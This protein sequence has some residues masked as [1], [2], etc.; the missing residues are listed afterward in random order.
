MVNAK[1]YTEQGGDVTHIGGKLVFENG[2]RM[3]GSACIPNIPTVTGSQVKDVKEPFNDLIKY[4]KD[5]GLMA[6]DAW[7]V[8]ISSA[9]LH[10]LPTAET[11]ANSGHATVSIDGTKITIALDC[12]VKDLADANHGDKWGTHKWLGF[13]VTTGLSSVAGVVFDD[14]TSSVTLTAAD[15]SEASDVGLSAGDFILY[16]KA[17]KVF[18]KGGSFTLSGLGKAETEFTMKV[19]ETPAGEGE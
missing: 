12:E 7:S 19:T 3:S 11:L 1:N 2:A 16:I 17:E 5:M 13:G 8:S 9:T 4:L 6:G 10:G 14:G 15:D 18:E